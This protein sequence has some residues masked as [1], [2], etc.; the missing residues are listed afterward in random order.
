MYWET[1]PASGT[2]RLTTDLWVWDGSIWSPVK[3]AWIWSGA[4]WELC[5]TAPASLDSFA[6]YDRICDPTL[7]V[8]R[9]TWSYTGVDIT[10]WNIAVDYS[11]NSGA[12]YTTHTSNIDPTDLQFDGTLDGLSGFT[13]LDN[14]Y[15]RLRLLQGSVNATNSPRYAYPTFPCL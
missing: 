3:S 9:A 11:F 2:W 15:F 5:H 12:S 6:I 4:Q 10:S 1:D 8:F 7:G 14:T 13:S